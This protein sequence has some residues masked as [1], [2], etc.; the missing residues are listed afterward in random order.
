MTVARYPYSDVVAA[1]TPATNWSKFA[2]H[3]VADPLLWVVANYTEL[4]PNSLTI[5][6]LFLGIASAGAYLCGSRLCVFAGV[7]LFYLSFGIDTIDGAL[8]RL[9]NQRSAT[10][11]WIDTIGDFIRSMIVGPAFAIGTYRQTGDVLALYVGFVVTGIGLLYYYLAEVTEKITRQR[12]ARM[13][14]EAASRIAW[15]RRLGLVPSPFGLADFEAV[16]LIIFPLLGHPIAGMI[17]SSV[18]GG[19]SRLGSAAFVLWRLRR[20]SGTE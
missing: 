1:T 13:A 6:A 20:P 10:G 19:L 5:A 9:T 14:T 17:V 15:I 11:A 3:P 4:H 16:Y 7:A 2:V 8:A 12:P 18:G